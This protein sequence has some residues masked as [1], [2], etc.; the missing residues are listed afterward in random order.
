[1][2]TIQPKPT[3]VSEVEIPTA[4][5]VAKIKFEFAHKGRKALTKFIDS[6]TVEGEPRDDADAL[7]EIVVGW[8]GVDQPFSQEA[9]ATLVDNYP[10]A[11]KSL[12][13]AYLPAMLEGKAAAKN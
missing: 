10:A 13:N 3:F 9:L 4:D 12:F 5:G 1:M 7:G 11:A 2:F 6:L 8:K